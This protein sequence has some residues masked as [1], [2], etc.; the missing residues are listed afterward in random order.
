MAKNEKNEEKK[1][2]KNLKNEIRKQKDD[3]KEVEEKEE[4]VVV[5][6]K[7][8]KKLTANEKRKIVFKI[9]G[10]IMALSMF[11]GSLIALFAPLMYK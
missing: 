11:I 8:K 6:A 3:K 10:W 2:T 1:P 9:V 5:K 7:P 4:K